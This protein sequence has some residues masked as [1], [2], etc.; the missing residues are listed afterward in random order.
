MFGE[1]G[2]YI[3]IGSSTAILVLMAD[4]DH[5]GD[6]RITGDPARSRSRNGVVY[7]Q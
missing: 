1:T 7:I 5:R 2:D 3:L 4:D 6:L